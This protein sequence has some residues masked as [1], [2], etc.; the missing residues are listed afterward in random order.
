VEEG[1]QAGCGLVIGV[2]TGAYT[3]EALEKYNPD[4]IIDRLL[5][6][7]EILNPAL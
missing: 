7:Q 1:R 3:R 2:T 4:F 6:L 5:V